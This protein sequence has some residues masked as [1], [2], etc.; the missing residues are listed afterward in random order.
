MPDV[1]CVYMCMQL[2]LRLLNA[3]NIATPVALLTRHMDKDLSSQAASLAGQWRM[4]AMEVHRHAADAL[5][6]HVAIPSP[7]PMHL[8]S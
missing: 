4:M 3:S 2:S 1:S 6:D 7:T 8:M 5:G